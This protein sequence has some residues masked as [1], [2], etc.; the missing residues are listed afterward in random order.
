MTLTEQLKK[1]AAFD[2]EHASGAADRRTEAFQGYARTENLQVEAARFEH[3]RLQPLL[4]ALI[5]CVG[6]LERECTVNTVVDLANA[7]RDVVAA[8]A[9]LA[10]LAEGGGD[11]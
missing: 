8:L 4:T 11:V 10:K 3:A 9:R 2:Q 1:L 6:A 7:H 5:E